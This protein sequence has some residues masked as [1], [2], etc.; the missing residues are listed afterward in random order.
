MNH[1]RTVPKLSG[2]IGR[3]MDEKDIDKSNLK[4]STMF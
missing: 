3:D 1:D 4:P 2:I